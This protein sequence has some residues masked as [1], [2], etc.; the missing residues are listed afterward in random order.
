[1]IINP[2]ITKKNIPFPALSSNTMIVFSTGCFQDYQIFLPWD[3]FSERI[4]L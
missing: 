1:M 3:D 2:E 4:K